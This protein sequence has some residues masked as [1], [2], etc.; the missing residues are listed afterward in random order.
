[1]SAA[2]DAGRMGG[3]CASPAGDVHHAKHP[4]G[5]GG[6]AARKDADVL[7]RLHRENRVVPVKPVGVP[8]ESRSK[9][10]LTENPE[11]EV[12]PGH[13]LKPTRSGLCSRAFFGLRPQARTGVHTRPGAGNLPAQ[14]K[15][16]VVAG[17]LSSE[18][19]CC[20]SP[21]SHGR[22][23]VAP[24]PTVGM[25]RTMEDARKKEVPR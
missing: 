23:S 25:L 14:F 24:G 9:I 10:I 8:L 7:N 2:C 19:D 1:M 15:A 21:F 20:G 16:P 22:V 11:P 5:F 18:E 17:S 3:E 13:D 4:A 6:H 12:A